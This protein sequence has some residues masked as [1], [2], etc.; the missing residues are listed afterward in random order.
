MLRMHDRPLEAP[1][2]RPTGVWLATLAAVL[3]WAVLGCVTARPPAS[4]APAAAVVDLEQRALVLLLE[5]RR[6]WEP[7]AVEA[8]LSAGIEARRSLALA[9]GRIADPRG[10]QALLQLLRDREP[11]VRR[12]A[13]FALAAFRGPTVDAALLMVAAEPDRLAGEQAIRTLGRRRVSLGTVGGAL[14]DLPPAELWA[15]LTPTL[16]VFPAAQRLATGLLARSQAPAELRASADWA[17]VRDPPPEALETLRDLLTGSD[18][19]LRGWA[20]AALGSRGSGD[21]VEIVVGLLGDPAGFVRLQ[22]TK[23]LGE[24]LRRGVA[25][26]PTGLVERLAERLGDEHAGVRLAALHAARFAPPS[27]TLTNALESSFADLS[28]SAGERCAAL[29]ALGALG[30]P[31]GF[32]LLASAAKAAE[33]RLRAC[34]AA[35][36]ARSGL[37][38]LA[39]TLVDDP[40]PRV[41]AAALVGLGAGSDPAVTWVRR[42]LVDPD[43]GVRAAASALLID[44]PVLT[45]EDLLRAPLKDEIHAR[46]LPKVEPDV[47]ARVGLVRAIG[48]RGGAERMERGAAL[49]LLESVVR[50]D[51]SP[52][53]R[54]QAGRS[55]EAL[56]VEAP[57]VSGSAGLSLPAYREIVERTIADRQLVLETAHGAIRVRLECALAPRACLALEQLASQGFYDGTEVYGGEPGVELL[58]GDRGGLGAGG[59]GYSLR[60]EVTPFAFDRPGVFGLVGRFQDEVGSAFFLTVS[61]QPW[62]TGLEVAL[63]E[64]VGGLE[65]LDRLQIG[66]TI[67]R[68]RVAPIAVAR[69]RR[70]PTP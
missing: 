56:G 52:T 9:L 68:I 10:E 28:R 14:R 35:V 19:W 44:R 62:R 25:R 23:A 18:P 7:V 6:L 41:R 27:A 38:S 65:V 11:E 12:A 66:D 64:V 40:S 49:L 45:L 67:E 29:E 63:G 42:G 3:G 39:V 50:E 55:V 54:A 59:P 47:A 48:A 30:A 22:A 46:G 57:K 61:P 60:A 26:S 53:V 24:L 43:P 16:S 20:V 1:P 8:A 69:G 2:G 31:R 34:A 15:R 70:S 32:D 4:A 5:D 51:P 17:M 37:A 58:G 36:A 13:A 33:E 21:D